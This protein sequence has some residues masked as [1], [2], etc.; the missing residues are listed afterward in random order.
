MNDGSLFPAT[1]ESQGSLP[2]LGQLA[3]RLALQL[4]PLEGGMVPLEGGITNRNYRV[5]FGG[6]DYV[7]RVPGK[8][9]NL[10]EI[11]RSAERIANERAARI[12]IAPPVAA[13]LD[14]PQAIV[15]LF[16]EGEGVDAEALREPGTLREV[17]RSLRAMHE[18]GE[19]L[20]VSFDSFR[21]VETYAGTARERGPGPPAEEYRHAVDAAAR[22]EAALRGRE[23]EP[24]PCH[25]DLLAANFIRGPKRLWIVDWEYAGMGNR[26]FDLANFAVN[27]ELGEAGE[28]VLLEAYFGEPADARRCGTLRVMRFM[29]DFREAMWGVVQ[30]ALSEL[31]FD[32][33]GYAM[34]HFER[35]HETAAHPEYESWLEAAGEP[36][37]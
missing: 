35:M 25:N 28:R 12:G 21:I 8:D 24:V 11:D 36:A 10:L 19:P 22:I 13:A 9:T 3:K 17:S 4:G 6:T 2:N 1:D 15:T 29:S 30:S 14:N 7:V 37:D 16:V 34:K 23:H 18:L 26:Y 5:T 31:D 33:D 32:F 20:P 27:N